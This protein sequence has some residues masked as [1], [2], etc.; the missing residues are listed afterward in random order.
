MNEFTV[1]IDESGDE[2]FVVNPDG[3]GST[4]W[5]AISAVAVRLMSLHETDLAIKEVKVAFG[6]TDPGFCP[7]FRKLCHEQR[8]AF[9]DLLAKKPFKT[10]TVMIHKPSIPDPEK[11][12]EKY[13]LYHFAA[14]FLLERVSWLCRETRRTPEGRAKIIF[15]NRAAMSY[16]NLRAYLNELKARTNLFDVRIDWSVID[17]EEVCSEP[18]PK[19]AGLQI[20]DAVASGM[21]YGFARNFYGHTEPRY[22]ELLRPIIHAHKGKILGY[23]LKL[24]PREA[25]SLL[26]SDEKVAWMRKI[27]H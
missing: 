24:W 18:H 4:R 19:L 5:F 10:V 14:R 23:G 1:F 25:D 13:L 20:A 8:V 12:S 16:E 26:D 6:K 22:A 7:H 27:F 15:S 2:G 11:F 21:Y 3:S 17:P 9:V